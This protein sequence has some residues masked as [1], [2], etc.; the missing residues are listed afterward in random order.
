MPILFTPSPD[1][2][3]T[4]NLILDTLEKRANTQHETLRQS[5]GRARQNIKIT[6]QE[7]NLPAYFSQTDPIPRLT[8]NEQFIALEKANLLKLN[9]LPG[10]TGNL[11]QSIVFE[12]RTTQPEILYT[13]L[14][15]TPLSTARDKLDALIRAELFRYERDDWRTR[16]LKAILR[17]IQ[18]GKS[19]AP[20]SLHD[21]DLN[22]GLLTALEASARTQTETPYR[23]FSVQTFN[24]SKRFEALKAAFV[25][26]ARLGNPAWKKLSEKELLQELN[27]VANPNYIHLA[28]NWEFTTQHG[29][30]LSLGGFS[31]SVGFPAAQIES[32]HA[33]NIHADALLCIENL[34]TFHEFI[35]NTS[36]A[37]R[38]PNSI[39]QAQGKHATLCLLGNPSPAI[40]QLLKLIPEKTPIYLWA[41]LDY[42]GFNILS[43]LR[44]EIS[45]AIQ[46]YRM[47]IDT[48][49]EHAMLARPLTHNDAR[50][51]RRLLKNRELQD[52]TPVI[53]HLLRSEL[54][55]E[56]EA[57]ALM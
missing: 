53:E 5:S 20:F 9:W 3:H 16:A 1:V 41:D 26:L 28:G 44:R 23:V 18:D 32:L 24:D 38:N 17:K 22:L 14:N 39:D 46:P 43:Q 6:F 13:I 29:E 48:F 51:L 15:R 50:N 35:R 8:A 10:E 34:T 47:N 7:A 40:R 37:T 33:A 2:A 55:L 57:I 56:Q 45:P 36:H 54:K 30:L 25:R 52:V 11:L 42:G 31:P 4:L 49:D 19:P 12:T 21:T 27:L